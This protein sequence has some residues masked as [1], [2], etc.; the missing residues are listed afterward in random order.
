[1]D[2]DPGEERQLLAL[3]RLALQVAVGGRPAEELEAALDA[4]SEPER[5][6]ATFVTLTEGDRL[7]GCMGGLDATR[8]VGASVATSALL[9]AL[10]DPRFR[11]VE[12]VELPGLTVEISVLG[13][14]REVEDPEAFCLGTDGVV[15]EQ[16]GRRGLLL[17]EVATHFGLDHAAMLDLV[18]LKAGLPRHAW[19][20]RQ[21]RLFTF[22]THRFGGPAALTTA[23][24]R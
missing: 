2:L 16:A 13:P 15:V 4:R 18:C 8:P 22:R 20:S 10:E 17:P 14:L 1:V 9:A 11:A 24:S 19:R 5:R 7:R 3:A 23:A 12:A 6:A 21:A